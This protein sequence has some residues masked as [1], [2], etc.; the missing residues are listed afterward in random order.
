MPGAELCSP[1]AAEPR[2]LKN[3]AAVSARLAAVVRLISWRRASHRSHTKQRRHCVG[4]VLQ[5]Y[6]GPD[7][8]AL[9]TGEAICGRQFSAQ[10]RGAGCDLPLL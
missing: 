9:G 2:A 1:D 7:V 3:S 8:P 10:Q 6:D 4:A 5:P